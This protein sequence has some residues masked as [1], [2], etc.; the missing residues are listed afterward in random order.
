MKIIYDINQEGYYIKLD[1]K[2][3]TT[4]VDTNNISEVREEFIDRMA[5]LFDCTLCEILSG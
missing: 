3:S 2:E 5:R 1:N 4:W